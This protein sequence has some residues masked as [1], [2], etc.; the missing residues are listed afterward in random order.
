MRRQAAPPWFQGPPNRAR[1]SAAAA[2]VVRHRAAR[3]VRVLRDAQLVRGGGD[4]AA[5]KTSGPNAHRS[6]SAA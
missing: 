1:S 5:L 4:G 3:A 6:F 2:S